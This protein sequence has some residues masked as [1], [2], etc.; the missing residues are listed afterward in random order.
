MNIAQCCPPVWYFI[1]EFWSLF[2]QW[3]LRTLQKTFL[4]LNLVGGLLLLISLLPFKPLDWNSQPTSLQNSAVNDAGLWVC[5]GLTVCHAPPARCPVELKLMWIVLQCRHNP[6][7][8][9]PDA[10]RYALCVWIRRLRPRH[11]IWRAGDKNGLLLLTKSVKC[12]KPSV[13]LSFSLSLSPKEAI[14]TVCPE[15]TMSLKRSLFF[16]FHYNLYFSSRDTLGWNGFS[17][18]NTTTRSKSNAFLLECS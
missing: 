3:P 9:L 7:V 13:S 8:F 16:H 10:K 2:H 15:R 12:T 14:F 5:L 1:M 6:C 4:F 17:S 11:N 18:G